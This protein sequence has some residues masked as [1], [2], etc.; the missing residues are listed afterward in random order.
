MNALPN[1]RHDFP[2]FLFA[3]VVRDVGPLRHASDQGL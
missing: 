2:L 1:K 3:S